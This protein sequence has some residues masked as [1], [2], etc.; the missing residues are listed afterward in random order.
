MALID[1]LYTEKPPICYDESF[2]HQDNVRAKSMME[3]VNHLANDG[4]QSIIFTCRQRE[5][6]LAKEKCAS[7]RLI[8]IAKSKE[9]TF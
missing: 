8:K 6:T 3:A 7:A 2:A 4:Y 5:S 1:M 9:K